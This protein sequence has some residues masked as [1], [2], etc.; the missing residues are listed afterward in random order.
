MNILQ[1]GNTDLV[2]KRF[3][4]Y[5]LNKYFAAKGHS[6]FHMVWKKSSSDNNVIQLITFPPARAINKFFNFIEKIL[7]IQ[8]LVSPFSFIPIFS[9][10]FK[11]SD[12][13]HY[14]ILHTGFFSLLALPILTRLKPS[15]W[16]LHD[17]WALTGHC[18]HPLNRCEKWKHGCGSC[19]DLQIPLKL[20]FDN[21]ALMWKIKKFIYSKSKLNLV[22]ASAWMLK[23]VMESPLTKNLKVSHIPLGI[24]LNIFKRTNITL[25]KEKLG[26]PPDTLVIS[27]RAVNSEFKGL[28]YIK[29]ALNKLN[30]NLKICLLTFDKVG[31]LN[32]FS[33]KFQIIDLGWLESEI[34]ISDAYN[35]ADVFLMPSVAEAFGMMAIEAMACGKPIIVLDGTSLSEVT[36][37]PLGAISCP[38]GDFYSFSKALDFLVHDPSAR[39]DL[40]LA[41]EKLAIDNYSFDTHAQRVFDY[42]CEVISDCNN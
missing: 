24:D 5:C 30:T 18:I 3:N 12:I 26:I 25:A 17:P 33:D 31:L 38:Q 34:D 40:G 23:M 19:P 32:E 15:V 35:A 8:S 20:Y 39:E 1:F 16:T 9:K 28:D 29:Y 36:F 7:S 22:V 37:A 41:A 42:Y 6:C 21:T 2:G 10:F 13:V 14:H 4:G 11:K 27:F